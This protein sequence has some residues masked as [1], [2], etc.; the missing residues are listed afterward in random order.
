MT[1][2]QPAY[3]LTQVIFPIAVAAYLLWRLEAW[4]TSLTKIQETL[5]RIVAM[6]AAHADTQ[7]TLK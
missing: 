2:D 3:L 7:Q 1:P 4:M 6:L 5:L